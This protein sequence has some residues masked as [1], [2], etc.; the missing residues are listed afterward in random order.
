VGVPPHLPEDL[1]EF[2]DLLC[3]VG[4]DG[5]FKQWNTRT[6]PERAIVY[7]VARGGM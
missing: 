6:M 2:F 4:F 3:V 5:F 7:G 1:E